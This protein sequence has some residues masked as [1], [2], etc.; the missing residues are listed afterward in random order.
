LSDTYGDTR[1]LGV[2]YY[3][4]SPYTTAFGNTRFG[5]YGFSGT[6]SVMF[7]GDTDYVGG[8]SP[9]T[10][11][12]AYQPTVA[13][14]LAG[15]SPLVMAAS[16]R[17]RGDQVTVTL[18]TE[19]TANVAA[20]HA[21]YFLVCQD[22]LHD[23]PNLVMT[24]L[25]SEPFT[26]T[27]AGQALTIERTFPMNPAWNADILSIIMLVQNTAT[28]TVLQ[29]TRATPAYE[30]TVTIDCEPDGLQASWSL[31]GPYG[32]VTGSGDAVLSL[33]DAGTH[34][35]T[36]EQVPYWTGP[37]GPQEQTIPVGGAAT[38]NGIYSDGPFTALVA[39]GLGAAGQNRAGTLVDVD[40]DG[41]LDIHVVRY[42]E[43]DLLLRND[44]AMGFV[45]VATGA[46]ADAGAGTGAAWADITGDGHLDVCLTRGNQLNLVLKGDGLGGFMPL[47]V[48]GLSLVGPV[49]GANWVDFNL[50]GKLDLFLYQANT[51]ATTNVLLQ[52]YGDIGGGAWL[53]TGNSG[54]IS[55]GGN[56]AACAWTD[57]DLNGRLDP[58][59][60][61]RYGTNQLFQNLPY[62]FNDT[63]PAS[64]LVDTGNDA[65]AAWGDFD[66]DSDFDLYLAND[67]S[68]DKLYRCIS[69]F[70]F[71]LVT[72]PGLGDTGHARG[73][74]WADLDNDAHLDLYVPRFDEP[75]LILLGDGTGGFTRVMAGVDEANAGSAGVA[76]GDLDGDGR[77]D[78]FVPRTG[79][80]NVVLKN[81]LPA[82]NH[83]FKLRLVGGGA[84]TAAIG[85]RVV[86]T[87]GG[88]AQTRL[89]AS[90]GNS[91]VSL[92][93]HFGLGAATVVDQ[94]DIH[95]PGGLHQVITPKPADITLEVTEGQAPV[96]SAVDDAV[97]RAVTILEAARPNPF[98]PSTTIAFTLAAP[99]RATLSVYTVDGRLVRNLLD[100][101][102][103]AGPHAARWDGT[104]MDGR[105]VSSGTYL[106]RLRTASGFDRSGRMTLV[107]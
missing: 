66:N 71:E 88:V 63:S 92:E 49:E 69:P 27:T 75:D 57:G 81:G 29:A 90:G 78:I 24:T 41:D 42:G 23:H 10:M 17:I 37:A 43:A 38:Y 26:A 65:A 87:A 52:S 19:L 6:P 13:A 60:V 25:P 30:A 11:Y 12:G 100:G 15:S 36:W 83:W 102:L 97:P 22:G 20:G 68:S 74:V 64:G 5:Q 95:W 21:V 96:V 33:F 39:G 85:A 46:L 48:Y 3:L 106:Y 91:P 105:P 58:Y 86:V 101:S 4:T 2:T 84:N 72:G 18:D 77:V 89:L 94:I 53:F 47:T 14:K 99:D 62:G 9:G 107:K 61:K 98:N 16:Y 55:Y 7:D 59:V 54:N 80:T 34:T 93:Q 70:H 79:L 1:F 103:S 8:I 50:D 35:I 40:E 45:D 104:G 82:L 73:V 31:S 28:W 56:T 32:G 44:G 51:A 76:V 67:G